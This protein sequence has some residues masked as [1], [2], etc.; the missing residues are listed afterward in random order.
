ME[1]I[2]ARIKRWGNSFGIVLPRGV[3]EK[4]EL[5]EGSEIIVTVQHKKKMT[6]GDLMKIS[7][8]LGLDKKLKNVDTKK[9]L[10]EVD[11]AF[12]PEDK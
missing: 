11:E 4:E 5:D 8:K 2:N 6:A 7:R 12:W 1:Q 10:R 9:A 3:V